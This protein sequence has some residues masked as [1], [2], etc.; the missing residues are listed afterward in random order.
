MIA[1][2]QR[3][4]R[5]GL[6]AAVLPSMPALAASE[7]ERLNIFLDRVHDAA[8]ARWPEWQTRMGLKTNYDRWNDRS[9]AKAVKEHEITIRD[10]QRLRHG[11]DYNK[12]TPSAKLSYRLYERL[13]EMR[14]N[15]FPFRHHRYAVSHLSGPHKHIASFLMNRHRI[16][17]PADAHAYIARLRGVPQVMDQTV[18]RLTLR[19]KMGILPPRFVFPKVLADI[20]GFLTG[21]PF[22]TTSDEDT[23]ILGDFRKKL[24][25]LGLPKSA[26]A[27]LLQQCRAALTTAV[28]PAFLR[29]R[30]AMAALQQQATEDA[31]AWKFPDGAKFYEF[32]LRSTTTTE[33]TPDEIHAY[34]VT[35][36]ARIHDEMRKISK[37]LGFKGN[38]RALFDFV[39]HDPSN[40]YPNDQ[41]GRAA[42]LA[43]SRAIIA[44]MR[45]DLGRAFAVRP[46]AALVVKRI[47][48]YREKTAAIAFY[49]SPAAHGNRPGMYYVNLND[50]R[51]MPKSHL[52]ALAYHE[53]I[54]GHHMQIAIAQE[55]D[56]LPKFRKFARSTAY[57]E[58]WALYAERLAKEM[59]FY[60]APLSDFGRLAW[61]LLC[62]A[63]LVVDTGLYHKRWTR[64]QAIDYL[65]KT[66]PD[67]HAVNVKAI[68]RYI[69]WPSQ[70]TAYK[71][72]MREILA[73]RAMA[74]KRLGKDFKLRD[75]HRVV[76]GNGALPL[77][78]LGEV[79]EQWVEAGGG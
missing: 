1:W 20:D 79:V 40:Y 56:S 49:R 24:A 29:L 33:M 27:A 42:Y 3:L 32:A 35:E 67:S 75:F 77:D 23:L 7:S 5:L 71:I 6:L 12:L 16:D 34:G 14:I 30:Q 65:D 17:E 39:R 22:E 31:G 73:L 41:I 76:L 74:R 70:A 47:E 10:L 51:L 48:P 64:E 45:S 2:T 19:A 25:K 69:V 21:M 8:V 78:L 68:E 61:E 54:P 63:R 37:A 26:A 13:A 52:E 53:G 43:D 66:L 15:R 28:K 72:G 62:A 36:V 44:E 38:L 4:L 46:K 11:F 58:G 9:D 59:G 50:M 57:L 18:A 55:L 60:R